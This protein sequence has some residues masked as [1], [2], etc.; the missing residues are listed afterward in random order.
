MNQVRTILRRGAAAI[1]LLGIAGPRVAAQS[2]EKL[3]VCCTVQSLASLSEEVGGPEVEVTSFAKGSEN[4]HFIDARPSFVKALST[5]DL[6]IQQGL[7]LE[8]GWVPVI[9][10]QARNRQVLPG[11]RGFLDASLQIT[12]QD[13]P[14]GPTDRSMGDVHAQGNPHFM[15][16][17]VNGILVARAIR[18][19]LS[20]LK[21]AARDTFEQRCAAFERQVSA[22]LVGDKL[23][24]QFDTETVIK[25]ARLHEQGRLQG[26]LEKQG[27]LGDLGGWLGALLPF[28]GTKVV[29]DHRQWTYFGARFGLDLVGELEPKPGIAPTTSHLGR[30]VQM[31]QN[32]GVKLIIVSPGFDPKS[33]EFV[34][35]KTG[36]R[37]LVLAHEVRAVDQAGSYLSMIDYDVQQIVSALRF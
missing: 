30:V 33:G 12:P 3:R 21:P 9:L 2:E 8:I 16:D 14:Q 35:A 1:L 37:L 32:Q 34:A 5:A 22:A 13:V 29:S 25:L 19:K 10:Q 27:R 31:V 7:E 26:F 18:D 24:S 23:A 28:A 20:Q 36:A 15:T 4:P 17:P 11:E 6:F